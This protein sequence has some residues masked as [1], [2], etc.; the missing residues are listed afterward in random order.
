[1]FHIY[2]YIYTHTFFLFLFF[3]WFLGKVS[4]LINDNA[5]KVKQVNFFFFFEIIIWA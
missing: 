2:I 3:L 5:I 4:W 1:M